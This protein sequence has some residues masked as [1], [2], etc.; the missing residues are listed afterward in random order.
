MLVTDESEKGAIQPRP[1][2]RM[3]PRD[4]ETTIAK[5]ATT[6]MHT[7]IRENA[8]R[9]DNSTRGVYPTIV[10]HRTHERPAADET[11]RLDQFLRADHAG[12][13]KQNAKPKQPINVEQNV[14]SLHVTQLH[15]HKT[16]SRAS[17][18]SAQIVLGSRDLMLGL[19]SQANAR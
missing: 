11:A 9:S 13:S 6:S 12:I 2:N 16:T 10:D 4:K 8:T 7:T 19:G 1:C 3:S 15:E 5:H 18:L 17:K 14:S